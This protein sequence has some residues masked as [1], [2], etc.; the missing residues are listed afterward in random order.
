MKY[1]RSSE[2]THKIH[3][4]LFEKTYWREKGFSGEIVSNGG[5]PMLGCSTGPLSVVYDATND[6]NVPALVG[7]IAGRPGVEWHRQT[8]CMLN[9]YIFCTTCSTF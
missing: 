3:K 5:G 1:R 9:L 4:N 6:K 7:F 2:I 8:V